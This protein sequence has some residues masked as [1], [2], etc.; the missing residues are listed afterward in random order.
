MAKKTN[1]EINGNKYYRVTRT[2]G[3]KADGTP[4]KKQFYGS[5]IN[6][7]NEKA[8]KYIS[9]LKQGL[10]NG[11]K[12]M[13]LNI[14]FPEWLFN[15]KKIEVKAST[16]ESYYSIYKKYIENLDISDIPLNDIKTLKLQGCYNDLRE[17]TTINN[18]KKTHKVLNMFFSYAEKEGYIVKNPCNNI[19][20]PKENKRVKE[21]L[22][23]KQSFQYYNE[24]EIKRLKEVFTGHKYENIILFALGTGMRR[25]EIFG[26]QW[27]D[28]DFKNKEIKVIH[29]LS[30]MADIT[31]DGT[32]KRTLQLN[33]PKTE[34]SIRIIPMSNN[35][36]NLLSNIK[37]ESDFVFAP[38]NGH[39]DL[40]YF[41][42]V[43][44]QK[45]KE[46][47]IKDKTFHDLRHTFA[48][49]LLTHGA[50]LITVKELLGHSSIKTTEIYLE[51]LPKTKTEIINKIDYLIN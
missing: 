26:L 4:I 37:K 44:A 30:Y 23:K 13:T 8:D 22:N 20:L 36:Y 48:T 35:I 5:G 49:M 50:N 19:S 24:D 17:Q 1:T 15:I 33:T 14:L 51:A 38:N 10:V 3:H 29:N 25:G 16:F 42:K 47:N 39:F 41:Q 45:L 28:I 6:E 18:V 11:N 7:A 9:D 46:A 21:I 12:I 32:I 2:V 43:F 40:K 31:K 27:S 34:N